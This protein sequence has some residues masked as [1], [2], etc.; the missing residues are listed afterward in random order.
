MNISEFTFKSQGELDIYCKKWEP[1]DGPIVAAVQ[2]SH[3]MAE[4]IQRYHGFAEVLVEKGFVV[5]GN[6][7]RGHGKT[8]GS[9][10]NIGYFADENGWDKVVNDMH[11][12]TNIIKDEYENI[13]VFLLGHSM[14]SFLARTYIESFGEEIDGVILSGTGG[15]PG[16]AGSIGIKI[17]KKEI[18]EKGKKAKSEKLNNLSFGN[19]NKGFKPNRTEF[20]W[21]TRDPQVVD[22]Y[23]RDPYCGGV[24]TAGFFYDMLTGLKE[25]Y[26]KENIDKIPK[27]LPI[28]FISGEKDPVG[29]NTKGVLQ[30]I[31][32]YKKA[33]IKDIS[34]KFYKNARHEVLNEINREEV[35]WDIIDWIQKYVEKR[36]VEA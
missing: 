14:G 23:I 15:N 32:A 2:I 16:I 9:L 18:K 36:K 28:F 34:Y 33:G 31:K 10:E 17:A 35:Y 8:A 26:K 1:D 20:D 13:P 22:E 24:F 4:H 19:F 29:A 30:A 5:Y 12:L 3:G 21:L 25:I 27:N 6:D 7:H 11:T